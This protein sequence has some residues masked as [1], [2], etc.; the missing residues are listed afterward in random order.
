[1]SKRE[2]ERKGTGSDGNEEKRA[3]NLPA[4]AIQ[5]EGREGVKRQCEIVREMIG[6]RKERERDREKDQKRS[7]VDTLVVFLALSER[8]RSFIIIIIITD[9]LKGG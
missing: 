4:L 2:K 3:T 6:R 9:L 8:M 5:I 7:T 1:M